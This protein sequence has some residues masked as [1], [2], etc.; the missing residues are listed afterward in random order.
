MHDLPQPGQEQQVPW[1]GG[2]PEISELNPRG[3][4]SDSQCYNRDFPN[5]ATGLC[6]VRG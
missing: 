6:C 4:Y 2:L 1:R 3:Y 5:G